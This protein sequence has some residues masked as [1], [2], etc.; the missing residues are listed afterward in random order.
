MKVRVPNQHRLDKIRQ[1]ICNDLS[2]VSV[3]SMLM[4][5]DKKL[6][7]GYEK[8][9]K[10]AKAICYLFDSINGGYV[11]FYDLQ[12]CLQEADGVTIPFDMKTKQQCNTID[13]AQRIAEYTQ[14]A[15]SCAVLC[16]VLC[17][18]FW[19]QSTKANQSVKQVC[20][21]FD[22]LKND[23]TAVTEYETRLRNDFEIAIR[24]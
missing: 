23:A 6:H 2:V 22:E 3:A 9:R 15:F 13:D 17:D 18:K 16:T 7:F 8:M 10:A 11:D 1:E 14:K 5:C 24:E 20:A 19:I 4:V 12:E 21:I